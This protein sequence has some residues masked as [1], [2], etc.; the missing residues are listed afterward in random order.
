MNGARL[1]TYYRP[2]YPASAHRYHGAAVIGI[3]PR[4]FGRCRVAE[5]ILNCNNKNRQCR[6]LCA[7]YCRGVERLGIDASNAAAGRGRVGGKVRRQNR[8]RIIQRD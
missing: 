1:L 8:Q 6:R 5:A 3:A 7:E 2:A 4:H